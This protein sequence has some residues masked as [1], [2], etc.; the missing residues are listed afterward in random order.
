LVLL[1]HGESTANADGLFTGAWDVPLSLEGRRQA[2]RA[3]RLLEGF[4]LPDVVITSPLVRATQTVEIVLKQLGRSG[5]DRV[6]SPE[7][8]E[9]GYGILTGLPKSSVSEVFGAQQ[10]RR[11]RRSM[12]GR[13][14]RL[15]ELLGE[16]HAAGLPSVTA[17]EGLLSD[18]PSAARAAAETSESLAEV[19]TRVRRCL[20]DV[21]IP[22]LRLGRCTLVVA[23]GNSLRALV[24]ILDVLDVSGIERLN[25]P[26]G[27]PLLYAVSDGGV[28][29]PDSGRYLDPDSAR[30][31]ALAV[32]R[33]GGT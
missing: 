32:A 17:I 21:L 31:A 5:L 7:L 14:P 25:I 6:V 13:P 20:E 33:E 15:S 12:T 19:V 24:S 8:T 2:R 23:H 3:A 4:A 26:T 10:A 30:E 22:N 28:P 18:M 9:R 16:S 27:E 1:R 11:W 29:V